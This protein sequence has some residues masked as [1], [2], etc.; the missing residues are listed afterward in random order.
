MGFLKDGE[1]G[2]SHERKKNLIL[3]NAF[4]SEFF[5]PWAKKCS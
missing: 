5:L 1:M 4:P 3:F 2:G